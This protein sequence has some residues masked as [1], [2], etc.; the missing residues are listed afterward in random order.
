MV[1]AGCA[2]PGSYPLAE[3]LAQ[4]RER[5]DLLGRQPVEDGLADPG[6]VTGGDPLHELASGGSDLHDDAA[7]V[8]A[9]RP[10]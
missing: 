5:V 10:S 8:V 2:W 9:A 7:G 3:L 4:C 1:G 6:D